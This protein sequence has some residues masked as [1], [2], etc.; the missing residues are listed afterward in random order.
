MAI[1][2]PREVL[3]IAQISI[4]GDKDIEALPLSGDQ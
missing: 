4:S 1:A 3:L 2:Q